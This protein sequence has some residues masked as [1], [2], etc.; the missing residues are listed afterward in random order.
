MS[1][2]FT[3]FD[4]IIHIMSGGNTVDMVSLDFVKA[5]DNADLGV[6][7]HEIRTL[8]ITGKLGVKVTRYKDA[9]IQNII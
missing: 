5:F 1:A 3:V 9:Q 7:L 4:D 6:L 2:L 8:G